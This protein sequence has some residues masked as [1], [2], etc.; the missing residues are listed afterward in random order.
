MF[1]KMGPAPTPRSGHAMASMGSRV[2]V[3]GGIGGESANPLK[4]EDP[5]LIHVLDTSKL[6]GVT[7]NLVIKILMI[8]IEHIKYPGANNAPPTGPPQ[9][10][11]RN[12]SANAQPP[13]APGQSTGVR[14]MSPIG[15]QSL[16]EDPRRA[17]SPT[18][19]AL[20]NGGAPP[21]NINNSLRGK[22]PVRPPR[23]ET[24]DYDLGGSPDD[25]ITGERAMS[26]EQS[27]RARSPNALSSNRA[28]SPIAPQDGNGSTYEPMSMVSAAMDLQQNTSV[29]AAVA[30]RSVS[31]VVNERARSPLDGHYGQK[32][33]SPTTNG[34]AHSRSGGS[35]GNITADLIRDLK[36]K[37]AEMESLKKREAWMKAAL[38]KASRAGFVYADEG[39]LDTDTENDD[40]VDSRRVSEMVLNLKHLKAKIQVCV[41]FRF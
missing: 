33:T 23:E 34:F 28:A 15:D 40:D 7:R 24:E 12:A 29:V 4:P 20:I 27:N 9:Q 5:T 16:D 1:Q 8:L 19:R 32:P 3:L 10:L 39:Q 21:N 31:P 13:A 30:A 2:F 11:S 38:A 36:D 25:I 35:A 17:V 14:A 37:E 41:V 6:H 18:Q 22:V 26:P